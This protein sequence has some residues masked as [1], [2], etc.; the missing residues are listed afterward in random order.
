[1]SDT[2]AIDEKSG[3]SSDSE[4]DNDK[5]KKFGKYIGFILVPLVYCVFSGFV[6]F[7]CKVGQSDMLPK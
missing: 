3:F 5:Y 1:M 7:S 6:L 4:S 2:S